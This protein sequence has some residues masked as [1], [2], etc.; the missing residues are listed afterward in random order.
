MGFFVHVIT[1]GKTE[2][3][4]Y[5]FIQQRISFAIFTSSFMCEAFINDIGDI[6]ES[7]KIFSFK[8]IKCFGRH[9]KPMVPVAFAVVSSYSSLKEG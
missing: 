4:C 5:V 1:C 8:I 2:E 6:N 3:V 7:R 9:V